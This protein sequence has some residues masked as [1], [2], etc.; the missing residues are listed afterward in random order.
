LLKIDQSTVEINTVTLTGGAAIGDGF[1]NSYDNDRSTGDGINDDGG[2]AIRVDSSTVT[3]NSSTVSG[4]TAV[5]IRNPDP[6]NSYE[7][8]PSYGG[9][10]HAL[11]STLKLND[12]S[13]S[14]N[15]VLNGNPFYIT[16]GSAIFADS[17]SLTFNNS[18]VSNNTGEFASAVEFRSTGNTSTLTINNSTFNGNQ[19]GGVSANNTTPPVLATINNSIFSGNGLEGLSIGEGVINNSIISNNNLD[20]DFFSGSALNVGGGEVTVNN[21]TISNNLYN[22][23]IFVNYGTLTLNNTTV[24]GNK[25]ARDPRPRITLPETGGI[26]ILRNVT[27]NLNNSIIAGNRGIFDGGNE[28]GTFVSR[29]GVNTFQ[30]DTNVTINVN[31]SLI[32]D[33]GAPGQTFFAPPPI[34]GNAIINPAA[35][36]N[37]LAPL[38]DNG[39][40][41]QTHALVEG[42]PAIDAGDC[43]THPAGTE[44]Q[45]GEPRIQGNACDLGA[46]EGSVQATTADETIFTIPLPNNS[47]VIFGL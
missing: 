42:S 29:A 23:A 21:S 12:S 46:F 28:I 3:L 37:I 17:T 24:T 10:I 26:D 8:F 47:S 20:S 13:I 40:S 9:G 16:Y 43:I 44:D 7:N 38:A 30:P 36:D 19:G 11:S 31:N 2:G 27:L 39:G 33:S 45:R 32:G 25:R 41:T 22:G 35:I 6:E 14:N 15:T 5:G 18:S 34:N 4:N 1:Y